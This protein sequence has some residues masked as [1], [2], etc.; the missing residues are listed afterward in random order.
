MMS[1][2]INHI[3]SDNRPWQYCPP[4]RQP[5]LSIAD[6]MVCGSTSRLLIGVAIIRLA[7]RVK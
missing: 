1:I 3:I 2:G 7:H 4:K 5:T 6:E